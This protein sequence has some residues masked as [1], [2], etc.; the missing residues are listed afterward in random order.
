MT[1]EPFATHAFFFS[2]LLLLLLCFFYPFGAS[3]ARFQTV[4]RRGH[5]LSL[6]SARGVYGVTRRIERFLTSS[7]KA[8]FFFCSFSFS[9]VE[10]FW[11]LLSFVFFELGFGRLSVSFAYV[12]FICGFYLLEDAPG[13]SNTFSL[14]TGQY[15]YEGLEFV[16]L[17]FMSFCFVLGEGGQ[18]AVERVL[19]VRVMRRVGRVAIFWG[20]SER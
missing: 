18:E 6:D 16:L 17:C 7:Y 1:E 14:L 9:F 20:S 12:S 10:V 15:D 8:E 19:A 13:N 4:S 3:A 5:F 11:V 2:F